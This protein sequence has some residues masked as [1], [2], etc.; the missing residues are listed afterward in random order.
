MIIEGKILGRGNHLPKLDNLQS[1]YGTVPV[2]LPDD[3]GPM[4]VNISIGKNQE[5]ES[6]SSNL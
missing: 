3:S 1:R 6:Q 4:W 5:A 2:P